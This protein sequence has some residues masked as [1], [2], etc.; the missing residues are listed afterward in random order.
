MFSRKFIIE[1]QFFTQ[2]YDKYFILAIFQTIP[3][4][5]N[6]DE[7]Y[8]YYDNVRGKINNAVLTELV[9]K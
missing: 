2:M 9:E 6:V 3:D 5:E 7:S 4:D 1:Y 8:K